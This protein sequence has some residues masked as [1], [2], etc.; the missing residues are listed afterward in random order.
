[1]MD[2]Q[3]YI[4][5]IEGKSHAPT[6]PHGCT[7]WQG[8][9]WRRAGKYSYGRIRNPFPGPPERMT[10][11][12]LVYFLH[13]RQRPC[14]LPQRDAHGSPYEISHICHQTLCTNMQ[15]LVRETHSINQERL[16]CK[17][18]GHCSQTHTPFCLM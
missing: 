6:G 13:K 4:S 7:M 2:F 11:H 10:V 9:I 15:H 18:Q 5:Y 8:G 1:M 14:D 3:R 12:K 17:N 16:H